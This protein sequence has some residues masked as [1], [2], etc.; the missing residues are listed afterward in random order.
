MKETKMAIGLPVII[1][2]LAIIVAGGF[3]GY[4][5][6]QGKSLQAQLIKSERGVNLQAKKVVGLKDEKTF[7]DDATG[8][9][10]EG[11]IDGEG[12]HHLERPG[13]PSQNV[14]L[15]SS[16]VALDEYI[17]KQVKVWGETFTAEKA[18]WF[19]DV[20]RLELLE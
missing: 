12:S 16:V 15:V 18:G 8:T 7:K 17:D 13:G 11:G 2:T 9:L 4:L 20:A 14:Y 5:L 1:L 19:M 10:R 6:A 3:S